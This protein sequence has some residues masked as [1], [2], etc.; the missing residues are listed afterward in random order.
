ML[1]RKLRTMPPMDP[2]MQPK[3]EPRLPPGSHEL[4]NTLTHAVGFVLSLIG[5]GVLL[6]CVISQGDPWRSAG[7]SMYAA[8]LVAVYAAST[9][10]HGASRP[11]LRRL[12]RSLDQ[13][14]IYL[15]I[16]GTY[17]PFALT[18][19]R[20]GAWL[21]FLGLLWAIA[22]VGFISKVVLAHRVESVAVWLY[23]ILG[24][25]PVIAGI[26]MIGVVPAT[27][28]W[29]VLF[30]G[31][32]YTAGTIFLFFDHRLPQLHAIWHLFVIAGSAFHFFAI[33]YFVALVD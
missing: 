24:W 22:F 12:F 7:C 20:T 19:L 26:N 15:L 21:L 8:S 30:G 9:L 11:E 3:L 18:Y 10:S 32:T 2:H 31:L 33:W 6:V 25:L 1:F 28:L 14:F 27:A 4:V 13:G 17:T 23:V 5:A 16:V 29:W